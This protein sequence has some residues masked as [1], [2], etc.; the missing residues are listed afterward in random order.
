MLNLQS[1]L[2]AGNYSASLFP[3]E[4]SASFYWILWC[5]CYNCHPSPSPSTSRSHCT[6]ITELADII[7][8]LAPCAASSIIIVD[9]NVHLN[10]PDFNGALDEFDLQ[11]DMTLNECTR[12]VT[13]YVTFIVD[14]PVISDRSFITHVCHRCPSVIRV[15]HHLYRLHWND[16]GHHL[17]SK[18]STFIWQEWLRL[19]SARRM[20]YSLLSSIRWRCIVVCHDRY[21]PRLSSTRTSRSRSAYLNGAM[22]PARET[23]PV[24]RNSGTEEARHLLTK[25]TRVTTSAIPKSLYWSPDRCHSWLQR[26]QGPLWRTCEYTFAANSHFVGHKSANDLTL[27]LGLKVVSIS[28]CNTANLQPLL[29]KERRVPSFYLPVD[30][31]RRSLLVVRI[32]SR[33]TVC[34]WPR[35]L[36]TGQS[37][38]PISFLL[39]LSPRSPLPTCVFYFRWLRKLGHVLGINL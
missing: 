11:R 21:A 8:R 30:Y 3:Y 32:S 14:L 16:A 38:V 37:K 9:M 27:F 36:M 39:P 29:T 1:K 7:E 34:P 6:L 20:S 22:P 25:T 19:Q 10:D 4:S 23:L 26:S 15:S 13:H 31:C 35:F 24:I 28:V 12:P 5:P 33:Q 17:I 18:P 2:Y